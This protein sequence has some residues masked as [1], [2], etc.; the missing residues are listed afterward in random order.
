MVECRET[1]KLTK[2]SEFHR[3]PSDY[4]GLEEYRAFRRAL[5]DTTQ[6]S[7][8]S[9]FPKLS[10][11]VLEILYA[12][13]ILS[14][15]IRYSCAHEDNGFLK[16]VSGVDFIPMLLYNEAIADMTLDELCEDV[17]RAS[18]PAYLGHNPGYWGQSH[19]QNTYLAL[20]LYRQS[21]FGP[22]DIN[23]SRTTVAEIMRLFNEDVISTRNFV[24]ARMIQ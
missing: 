13:W 6:D 1:R 19:I 7:R 20:K 18:L 21:I 17:H 3:N 5:Y 2:D 12:T 15:I 22:A 24:V 4:T 8:Y 10:V 14:I 11:M 9:Y 16:L 23:V